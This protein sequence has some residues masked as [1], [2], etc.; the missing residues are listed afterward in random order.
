MGKSRPP[1]V[2]KEKFIEFQSQ[3]SPLTILKS[4]FEDLEKMRKTG[5]LSTNYINLEAISVIFNSLFDGYSPKEIKST[6][7]KEW[8]VGKIT[9]YGTEVTLPTALLVSLC[10]DWRKYHKPDCEKSFGEVLEIEG[11]GQGKSSAK[12]KLK[13]IIYHRNL[14][15][16]VETQYYKRAE[17]EPISLR[18]VIKNI[19]LQDGITVD[20]VEKAHRKYYKNFRKELL[21]LEIIQ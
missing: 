16:R 19:A 20:T 12:K 18:K 9:E 15:Y 17:T 7:P 8:G 13:T 3:T 5:E 11:G 2:N 6:Y 10:H 14:A 4:I 21:G 1:E